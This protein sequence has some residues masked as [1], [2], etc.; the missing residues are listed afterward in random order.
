MAPKLVSQPLEAGLRFVT[1]QRDTDRGIKSYISDDN[2]A[3]AHIIITDLA[4]NDPV[5][6]NYDPETILNV[7]R[8]IIQL[9]P[10][11]ASKQD[12]LRIA[13]R[14]VLAAGQLEPTDVTFLLNLEKTI[15]ARAKSPHYYEMGGKL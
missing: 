13:M 8:Q 4:V 7:Y 12:I 10:N 14:K 1:E 15:G 9:A 6:S 2:T 3:L 11:I 5:I